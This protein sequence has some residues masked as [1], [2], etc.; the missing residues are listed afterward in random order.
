MDS[1]GLVAYRAF[2]EDKDDRLTIPDAIQR[3][4]RA[5]EAIA[6][7]LRDRIAELESKLKSHQWTSASELCDL[8]APKLSAEFETIQGDENHIPEGWLF[9]R[10]SLDIRMAYQNDPYRRAF[11]C[12]FCDC[13]IVGLPNFFKEQTVRLS[14]GC[15]RDGRGANCCRCGK[16]LSFHGITIRSNIP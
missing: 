3:W 11:Y 8:I 15:G 1:L 7:P 14:K 13:W 2:W 16:E 4:D 12:R 6:K 10:F 5:A 9:D